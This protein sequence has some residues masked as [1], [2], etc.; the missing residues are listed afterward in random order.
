[1]L[2]K[3]LFNIL[4]KQAI[5]AQI[6]S[7]ARYVEEGE[8]STQ[9]FLGLEKYRQSNNKITK[10]KS[11]GKTITNS[12]DILFECCD[13]YKKLYKS[14]NPN[15]HE[16]DKFIRA[17]KLENYLSSDDK[18]H[19]DE[20]ISLQEC[21]HVVEKCL[22][23]NKSPGLDGLTSEFYKTFWPMIGPFLIEVYAETF[24]SGH[25]S[26]SQK[27]AVISLFFKSGDR[28]MLKNYRPISLTN[29]DY[30]ILAFILALRVQKVMESTIS[31]DQ[32]G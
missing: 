3:D 22:K 9:H 14:T 31:D 20:E 1:M 7:R 25:L 30:K 10:L 4:N 24:K 26:N 11:N 23:K 18:T 28:D 27:K 15:E 17:C 6:R 21:T 8:K 29:R 2:K 19:C 5:G 13:F 16:I 12:N 32:S